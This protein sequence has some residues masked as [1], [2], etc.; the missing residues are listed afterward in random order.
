MCRRHLEL[1]IR[2]REVG[3]PP[4]PAQAV[5]VVQCGWQ[6][7]ALEKAQG[8][9]QRLLVVGSSWSSAELSTAAGA[10]ILGGQGTEVGC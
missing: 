4:F 1:S 7:R 3:F 2:E 9:P 8:L 10:E 5:P 6:P